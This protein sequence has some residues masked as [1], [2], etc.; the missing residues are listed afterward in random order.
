MYRSEKLEG[1]RAIIALVHLIMIH[2][3]KVAIL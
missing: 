2:L 3:N 1:I